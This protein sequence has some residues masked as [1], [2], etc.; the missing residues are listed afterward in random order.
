MFIV[1]ISDILKASDLFVR[2]LESERVDFIF[3]LPGE[4]N[5]DMVMSL[6]NSKIQFILTR[7]EQSAAFMADVYGRLTD[8]VGVCL[9]TLGPGATNLTT[10]IA[11]ANMDR[12]RVLA[13]TGQTDVNSL[14]KESHQNMDVITMFKPIT[15]WNWSIR[16]ADSIPEVIRRSFKISLEE[17]VGATHIE[18]PQDIAKMNSNILPIPVT[19]T[20]RSLPNMFLIKKAV[21]LILNAKKPLILVG[22][23]CIRENATFY[24]RKFVE[25][26]GICSM[27]TFMAKGVI[28]DKSERHLHTIGIKEADHALLAMEESDLV[29]A[30]G[31]DLVEYS[32]KFWNSKLDKK[33]IHI[34]FTPSEVDTYYPPIVEIAADIE[35]TIDSILSELEKEKQKDP[36]VSCYPFHDMPELFRKIKT[37]ISQN[38]LEYT[39]DSSYPIKPEKLVTDVRKILDDKDIV[40]SDVG[41]HKLWIAK[42]YDTYY[43]NTC[44]IPNG[45]CSMGFSLPGALAAQLIFPE[46][47]IVA[48]CGDGSFLMNVQELETAVRLKLPI[49]IVVWVDK[50]FGLIALKQKMEF[51]QSGFTK[52]ENPDFVMLAESFGAIGF[53]VNSVLEFEIV[54]KKAIK[55]IDVPVVIAVDVDY[56]R[57]TILLND[58]YCN[59]P[60]K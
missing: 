31:Y 35:L 2:C 50:E 39:S 4:E 21:Q 24:V 30:I 20:L 19:E 5:A 9:A 57:N 25:L 22:N 48:M 54:F 34:D 60:S 36:C 16:N 45:F 43:P 10:G 47:K 13:I 7:H 58:E 11:N 56:S 1:C 52:F 8:K 18:L 51:G 28:S 23:G 32:P 46:K 53:K 6:L 41:V 44:I 15:K 55:S 37:E 14:H 59:L 38:I 49:I 33:I 12:S 26:T 3:G 29:I 17:K 27:N 40:S 42:I